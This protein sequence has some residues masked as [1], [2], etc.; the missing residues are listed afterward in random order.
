MSHE[1]SFAELTMKL[2]AGDQD[3]A[4]CVFKAYAHRLIGL[5]RNRLSERARLKVGDE[6]VV[7]SALLSFFIHHTG[8]IDLR[9]EDSLWT[10]LLAI[11]LRHCGKWNKRFRARK[12]GAP[13]TPLQRSRDG[14]DGG[15]E[16]SAEEPTP[17]MAVTLADLVEH[18]MAG[19]TERQRQV[20]Q[21]RLQQ[22]PVAEI[23]RK[24]GL[25]QARVY[26]ILEEVREYGRKRLDQLDV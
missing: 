12:R 21:L 4:T 23:C 8:E 14:E 17:E 15:L 11:T 24:V 19:L 18:L 3:A 6:A 20:V 25:S 26:R 7:Q 1:W 2:Q 10:N 13:E 9:S 16:L 5:A 22:V